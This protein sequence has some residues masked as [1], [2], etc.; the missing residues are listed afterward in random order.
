KCYVCSYPDC[1]KAY[2]RPVLLRQHENSHENKRPFVCSEEGCGKAF[3]KKS[4]LQDHGFSHLP[5]YARPYACTLCEKKFISLDRLR[6]HELTHT[7]RYK[8]QRAGCGHTYGSQISLR[9]H[10]DVFHDR[11][12]NCDVCNKV[13]QLRRLVKEHRIKKHSAVPAYACVVGGCYAVFSNQNSLLAHVDSK[14]PDL[15]CELCNERFTGF[16][17]LSIH[18]SVHHNG[19]R[20]CS[21]D[22]G[23]DAQKSS[24]VQKSEPRDTVT[25]PSSD[26][27]AS[28][29]AESPNSTA[30]DRCLAKLE[31]PSYQ[32]LTKRMGYVAEV[33]CDDLEPHRRCGRPPTIKSLPLPS[34]GAFIIN[35]VTKGV[36]KEYLCPY[37]SCQRKYVRKHAYDKHLKQHLNLIE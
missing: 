7:E 30:L 26:P 21:V 31:N 2:N 12:L 11:V 1:E 27:V 6:R 16:R 36:A 34:S 29:D 4:N 3:F 24:F 25:D 15:E 10:L 17:A 14:H 20:G 37:K 18:M 33:V 19:G 13:F 28:K 35:M 22:I 23:Y 8:C 9:H 32:S 5:M